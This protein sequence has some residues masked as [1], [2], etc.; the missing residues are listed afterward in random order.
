MS[1]LFCKKEKVNTNLKSLTKLKL[2]RTDKI[3]HD[4][5][6]THGDDYLPCEIPTAL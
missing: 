3:E 4:S 5:S 2:K 6:V 1:K